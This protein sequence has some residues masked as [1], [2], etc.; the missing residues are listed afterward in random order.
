MGLSVVVVTQGRETLTRA[1][2]SVTSQMMP[3]D[4]LLVGRLAEMNRNSGV[5]WR[6]VGQERNRLMAMA[7]GDLMFLDDDDIFL[8]GALQ[9]ARD[10][11]AVD[12]ERPHIFQMRYAHNGGV[13][14]DG[15]SVEIGNIGTPMLVIPN[16]RERVGQWSATNCHDHDFI[17]HTV[18]LMGEPA[19]H[20]IVIAELNP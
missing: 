18:E 7:A 3:D 20:R 12:S 11:L 15:E 19:W 13:L 14:F 2:E 4:E 16:D 10:A 8:P 9:A 5:C 17:R 6:Y 1:I